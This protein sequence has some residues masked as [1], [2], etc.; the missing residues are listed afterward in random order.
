[1]E[2]KPSDLSVEAVLSEEGHQVGTGRSPVGG[3]ELIGWKYPLKGSRD[4]NSTVVQAIVVL[5][6][7]IFSHF[8][9][10]IFRK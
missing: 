9:T 7:L 2:F 10:Y 4:Q 3:F 5:F 1:M 6:V 8:V